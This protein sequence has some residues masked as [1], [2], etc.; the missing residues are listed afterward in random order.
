M[1][2]K[3]KL[4]ELKEQLRNY[5]TNVLNDRMLRSALDD[6][7]RVIREFVN[8]ASSISDELGW[9]LNDIVSDNNF[10]DDEQFIEY[11]RAKLGEATWVDVE[12]WQGLFGTISTADIYRVDVYDCVQNITYEDLC[13]LIDSLIEQLDV[14]IED[15]EEGEE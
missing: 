9:A 6:A 4:V 11:I 7:F 13:N 1:S 14:D 15:C 5:Q 10:I 8:E 3:E 12:F 2:K